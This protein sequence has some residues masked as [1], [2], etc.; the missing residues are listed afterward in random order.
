MKL[1]SVN[2]GSPREF[3]WNGKIVRTSIF[4][5]PVTGRASGKM[6]SRVCLHRG[7]SGG[8]S[9]PAPRIKTV[10][11][12]HSR[13]CCE[14]V[15]K[16]RIALGLQEPSLGLEPENNH[17]ALYYLGTLSPLCLPRDSGANLSTIRCFGVALPSKTYLRR[18][19]LTL[20]RI[21]AK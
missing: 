18:A 11:L 4:Y 19:R 13:T 5:K 10:A 16:S 15:T 1:L 20:R 9:K 14:I 8:I 2:G 17:A 6:R 7:I 21:P 3:E 12:Y